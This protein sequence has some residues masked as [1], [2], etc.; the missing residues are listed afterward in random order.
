M[1][2]GQ[3]LILLTFAAAACGGETTRP[4]EADSPCSSDDGSAAFL[5]YGASDASDD[6]A[7]QTAKGATKKAR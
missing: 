7:G 2:W 1:N 4:L 5:G 6:K 3:W